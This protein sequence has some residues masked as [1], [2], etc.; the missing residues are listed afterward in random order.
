R[1]RR[2][3]GTRGAG[4]SPSGG[5]RRRHGCRNQDRRRCRRR[6]EVN[7]R[8]INRS[9]LDLWLKGARL[10]LSAVESATGRSGDEPWAGSLAF[11]RAASAVRTTVGKLT[12]DNELMAVGRLQDTATEKR[13]DALAKQAEAED[14]R[15]RAR[16]DAEERK[17]QIEEA[18]ET[19]E[20]RTVSRERELEEERAAAE[21]EVEKRASKRRTA[22]KKAASARNKATDRKETR[23]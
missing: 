2:R 3:S 16:R 9:A 20:D 12:G 22:T 14:L 13:Y 10:P 1:S 7:I 23:A 5:G 17:E 4:S 19:V 8:K 21:R 18:R 11:D 6:P 15:A